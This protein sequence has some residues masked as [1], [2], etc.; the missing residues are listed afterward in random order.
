MQYKVETNDRKA[1][2]WERAFEN[3]K[4]QDRM[5]RER[6]TYEKTKELH[7]PDDFCNECGE[8]HDYCYCN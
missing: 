1:S 4:A 7:R 6:D 8:L 5:D 2:P 3:G